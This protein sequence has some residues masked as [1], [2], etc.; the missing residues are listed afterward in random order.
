MKDAGKAMLTEKFDAFGEAMPDALRSKSEAS[1]P[2]RLIVGRIGRCVFWLLVATIV[3]ARVTC[4]PAP[5]AFEV[6]NATGPSH[7]L[8]R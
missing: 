2:A 5:P 1:S 6:S 3:A 7:T 4:Y 8:A